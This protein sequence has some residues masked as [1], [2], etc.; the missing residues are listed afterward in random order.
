MSELSFL[1]WKLYNLLNVI[2]FCHMVLFIC[3]WKNGLTWS[4]E[5]PNLK[6]FYFLRIKTTPSLALDKVF[7]LPAI[8]GA[9]CVELSKG[10]KN[11]QNKHS[12]SAFVFARIN[13]ETNRSHWWWPA[14]R[15]WFEIPWSGGVPHTEPNNL[16]QN[17]CNHLTLALTFKSIFSYSSQKTLSMAKETQEKDSSTN[18]KDTEEIQPRLGGR[19]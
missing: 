9:M 15:L 19:R 11:K 3:L 2:N 14:M 4:S 8:Q 12:Y 7:P 10:E 17:I 6:I 1:F 5:E 13:C 16:S 18:K